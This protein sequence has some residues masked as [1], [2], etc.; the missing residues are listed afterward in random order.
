MLVFRAINAAETLS[1][2]PKKITLNNENS[3][4]SELWLSSKTAY[5]TSSEDCDALAFL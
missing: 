5:W 4:V 1:C 2:C 3:L